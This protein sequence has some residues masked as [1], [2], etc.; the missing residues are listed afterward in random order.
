MHHPFEKLFMRALRKSTEE[1]NA[2]L[3]VVTDL[4]HKGYNPKEI[5]TALAHFQRSLI[6]EKDSEFVDEALEV[7]GE[8]GDDDDQEL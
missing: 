3:R 6:D 8:G 1:D 7:L 5:H 4:G 2:V